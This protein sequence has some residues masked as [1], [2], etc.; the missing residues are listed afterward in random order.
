MSEVELMQAEPEKSL[1]LIPKSPA[2]EAMIAQ[3]RA[4]VE[5]ACIMALR[6]PRDWDVVRDR[7]LKECRRPVFAR[8][9]EPGKGAIY[10][11]PIGEGVRGLSVRFAEVAA[12]A[13]GHIHVNVLTLSESQEQRK[14]AVKV[15]DAQS[16]NSFE[17]EA[18]IEKTIERKS[19]QKE[20]EF[21]RTRTNNRGQ[22]LY[23]IQATE[24][25]MLNKVNAAV[26][27]AYRNGVLRMIPGWLLDECWEVLEATSQKKD[28]EDPDTAK[29]EIFDAFSKL[30]V[31]TDKIKLIVGHEL[32]SV[33]PK[34]LSDLRALYTAIKDGETTVHAVLESL[35]ADA[36]GESGDGKPSGQSK[37]ESLKDRLKANGAAKK[38]E[39]VKD[40]PFLS[41]EEVNALY[42]FGHQHKWKDLEI[43]SLVRSPRFGIEDFAK[44]PKSKRSEIEAAL[45][46]R[47]QEASNAAS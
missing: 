18:T 35:H 37:T 4:Q 30:G 2:S 22:V 46:S 17:I 14:V 32:D 21:L 38:Q 23:V 39:P 6:Y 44:I 24:D 40:E 7:L 36:N 20:Q 9:R 31:G 11:K 41:K 3:A 33:E 8:G 27:K 42:E 10:K 28:A 34:E 29:R 13:A 19:I 25:D 1:E 16:M 26:S 47:T 43:I 5:A 45:K 15:W 12:Q